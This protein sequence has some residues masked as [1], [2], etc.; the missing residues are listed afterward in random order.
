MTLGDGSAIRLDGS[1]LAIR[2]THHYRV[3]EASGPTGQWKVASAAYW[4]FLEEFEGREI[5]SFHWHPNSRSHLTTP[6]LHLHQGA[7]VQQSALARAHVP[8][9]RVALEEFL[10]MVITDFEVKPLRPDWDDALTESQAGFDSSRT[11]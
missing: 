2:I 3:V 7:Q 10:R 8:T 1:D 4:Y 11:W 9:G 6:H 5:L